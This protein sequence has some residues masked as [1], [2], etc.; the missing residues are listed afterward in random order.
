MPVRTEER[1]PAEAKGCVARALAAARLALER[2]PA[3]AIDLAGLAAAAGV[4]PRSLQRQFARSL[5]MSPRAAIERLRLGQ[6]R[7]TL[8]MNAAPSVLAAAG[9]HGFDHPGRFA[10]AYARAFGEPPSET[11]RA[12]RA[13]PEVAPASQGTP[14]LLQP[15]VATTPQDAA[16]ARRATDDLAIALGGLRELVLLSPGAGVTPDPRH[17]LRLQGRIEAGFVILTLLHP[18]S[19]VVVR[20]LREALSGKAG[21]GWA[22]RAA[23]TVG[24]AIAAEKLALAQRT[25]RHRADVE[26]LVT[27]ARPAALSQEPALVAMALDLLGEALHRDPSHAQALAL[28]GWS[29]AVGA[30][31]SFTQEPAR[32]R[33]L[34]AEDAQKAL[35]LGL[36]DPEVLTLVAGV[37][38]LTHRLDEAE[39][40]VKRSLTLDPHQP[41]ALR[42]LGF[43]ENFRGRGPQAAAAFRRALHA[44]PTANDASMSLIGL[45]VANFLLADY[46]RAC[47]ALS[48]ALDLQP[49][50]F[51]PH[52]FL[53]AAAMHAGASGE[54][55]RSLDSLRRSFPDLTV[56]RCAQSDVLPPEALARVLDGLSRAGLPG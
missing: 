22:L 36:D 52:R 20:T 50:R 26:T 33:A 13:R 55:R 5:K 37:M 8:S 7:Q 34:A 3:G 25:P 15:L 45:G 31:H 46:A 39:C 48:R 40:L 32:A 2:E 6:A 10:I 56:E 9:R 43:I 17:S 41:E 19:G 42:R 54:A 11:L 47:R 21:G 27:R 53:T 12:A 35:A 14:V 18:A 23:R 24:A 16:R 28:A 38:S 4:S 30:N 29:R 51:W 1:L 44:A 49:A